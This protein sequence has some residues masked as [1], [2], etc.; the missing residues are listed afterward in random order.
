MLDSI[1]HMTLKLFQNH[2][3][4]VKTLWLCCMRDVKNVTRGSKRGGPTLTSFFLV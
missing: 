1:N 3:F 4:G 2:N